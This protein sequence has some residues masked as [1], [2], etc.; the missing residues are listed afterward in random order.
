MA[1]GGHNSSHL[2]YYAGNS[3]FS[4]DSLTEGDAVDVHGSSI[5]STTD[6]ALLTASPDAG[7]IMTLSS[8]ARVPGIAAPG[9]I[10]PANASFEFLV[11]TPMVHLSGSSNDSSNSFS[12]ASGTLPAA[13]MHVG[14]TSQSD[15]PFGAPP[16]PAGVRSLGGGGNGGSSRAPAPASL[17]SVPLGAT[18]LLW[19]SSR[20]SNEGRSSAHSSG[21]SFSPFQASAGPAYSANVHA[22]A[23]LHQLDLMGTPQAAAPVV[24]DVRPNKGS[25]AS[26]AGAAGKR[27]VIH[28]PTHGSANGTTMMGRSGSSFASAASAAAAAENDGNYSSAAAGA[29]STN[30][31]S[32]LDMS[33]LHS[34]LER[35]MMTSGMGAGSGGGGEGEAAESAAA[36][37]GS[38]RSSQAF[39]S[40]YNAPSSS[41]SSYGLSAFYGSGPSSGSNSNKAFSQQQGY[42]PFFSRS[43]GDGD[44]TIVVGSPTAQ[45][46]PKKARRVTRK[47]CVGG[48]SLGALAEAA[49]SDDG[50][51]PDWE[52]AGQEYDY[53]AG[54]TTTTGRR[55]KRG[56]AKRARARGNNHNSG[57]SSLTASPTAAGATAAAAAQPFYFPSSSSAGSGSSS[58]QFN[59][60][61]TAYEYED[62]IE[63]ESSGGSSGGGTTAASS[64]AT[65]VKSYGGV[66]PV[67]T[68][69]GKTTKGWVGVSWIP[70]LKKWRSYFFCPVNKKTIGCGSHPTGEQ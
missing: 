13:H 9:F 26:Y 36:A 20:S 19:R 64:D 2:F 53:S 61:S 16:A 8:S 42:L 69:G 59:F 34:E 54:A 48:Y 10:S 50:D 5:G 24:M 63:A 70:R 60:N 17:L 45:P 29:A 27:R 65:A 15:L 44:A 1:T 47:S 30:A 3:V 41:S 33:A 28:R 18:H 51:D 67:S 52:A 21:E 40:N 56:A 57:T 6:A 12:L 39:S 46:R 23:A 43:I 31:Y 49:A 62:E 35:V 14:G 11:I 68:V 32:Q 58:S 4:H 55:G 25:I 7:H 38:R 37:A 22:M 66:L